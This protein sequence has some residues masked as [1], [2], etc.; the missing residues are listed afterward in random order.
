MNKIKKFVVENSDVFIALNPM[1]ASQITMIATEAER[2]ILE[3]YKQ[4][5]EYNKKFFEYFNAILV[6]MDKEA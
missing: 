2:R 3:E 5:D 1:V 6:E 4:T